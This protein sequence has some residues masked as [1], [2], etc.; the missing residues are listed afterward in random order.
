MTSALGWEH[1]YVLQTHCPCSLLRSPMKPEQTAQGADQLFSCHS[2]LCASPWSQPASRQLA[3]K[4]IKD[5]YPVWA[6]FLPAR[7]RHV[8]EM[9]CLIQ[10]HRELISSAV[11]YFCDWPHNNKTH[12]HLCPQWMDSRMTTRGWRVCD[13]DWHSALMEEQREEE[14]GEGASRAVGHGLGQWGQTSKEEI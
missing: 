2:A 4:K 11:E 1:H 14:A 7:I 3:I 10:A 13:P 5:Q 12:P 6:T 8:A 9:G